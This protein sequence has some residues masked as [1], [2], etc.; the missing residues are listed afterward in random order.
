M[1]S[2]NVDELMS[3]GR[4]LGNLL[5]AQD[6]IVLSG[7]LGAGKTTLTKGIAQGLGIQLFENMTDACLFI[8]W[9]FIGLARIQIQLIWM[10][11]YLVKG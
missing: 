10:I 6:V 7:D 11:F 2:Q 5:V 4:R 8:I 9:M 3:F 1:F